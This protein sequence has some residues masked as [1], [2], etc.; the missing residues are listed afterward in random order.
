M[1]LDKRL[2]EILV[3][4]VTKVPVRLMSRDRL[5]ILNRQVETG[6]VRFADGSAVSGPIE[7]ALVTS[8]GKTIYRVESGVPVMLEDEAISSSQVPGW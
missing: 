7:E 4:P 1:S 2:L 6:D 5:A 3:C 8:D